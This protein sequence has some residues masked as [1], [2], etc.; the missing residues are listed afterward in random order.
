LDVE[1]YINPLNGDTFYRTQFGPCVR[2]DAVTYGRSRIDICL[3]IRRLT[4]VAKPELPGEA[5]RNARNQIAFISEEQEFLEQ[6]SVLY[7]PRCLEY[8]GYIQELNEHYADPHP[9]R[10]LR[11]AGMERVLSEGFE[12]EDLWLKY[13]TYKFKPGERARPGKYGRMVGDMGIEASLQGFRTTKYIK[14][15]MAMEDIT[16]DGRWRIRFVPSPRSEVLQETFEKLINPPE[17]GFFVYFSDDSCFSIRRPDGS[18]F[19]GNLDIASCDAS[20]GPKLFEALVTIAPPGLR[21]DIA[22]L[23]RQCT[24]PI[25]V[26]DIDPDSGKYDRRRYCQLKPKS[27]RLYSG[28]TITTLI[29]NLASI[30]IYLSICR[31]IDRGEEISA[32]GISRAAALAGYFIT[33][34]DASEQIELLQFLKHSPARDIHGIWRAL[35]NFG[36]FL[37]STGSCIRDLPTG[38]GGSAKSTIAQRAGAFQDAIVRCTF[39]RVNSPAIQCLRDNASRD[40]HGADAK[41]RQRARQE[42][43][44]TQGIAFY[45]RDD[46]CI[47]I[48]CRENLSIDPATHTETEA[49]PTSAAQDDRPIYEFNDCDFFARYQL[50]GDEYSEV[51]SFCQS[52]Q[53]GTSWSSEGLSRI[54]EADYNLECV[55]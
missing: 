10:F 18:I 20:H 28:A 51:L 38:T 32:D 23:C 14:E 40:S 52:A 19:R 17:Q 2:T 53:F 49:L 27:P 12:P 46:D 34:V 37:R 7:G 36:V 41:L 5:E 54:L 3:A 22:R 31:E 39:P 30:L 15:A 50:T 47:Y 9:K 45:E 24:V 1:P 55:P 44:K 11:I 4:A 8:K 21:E 13:C 42:V 25:R 48:Q 6:L 33:I 16:I 35:V 43:Q 29:N 26:Y